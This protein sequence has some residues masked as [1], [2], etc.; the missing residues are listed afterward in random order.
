MADVSDRD[1]DILISHAD[2][3][4]CAEV[5]N[6]E[7]YAK[8]VR[9]LIPVATTLAGLILAG[10]LR[11]AAELSARVPW[12][13]LLNWLILL[14]TSAVLLLT[15]LWAVLFMRRRES[16]GTE[17]EDGTTADNQRPPEI[18]ASYSLQLNESDIETA[19]EALS[20]LSYQVFAHT[21]TAALNLRTR[22]VEERRRIRTSERFVAAG[23]LAAIVTLVAYGIMWMVFL[24]SEAE[25][26]GQDGA[27]TEI[28]GSNGLGEKPAEGLGEGPAGGEGPAEGPGEAPADG[29][30][31]G[32][33]ENREQGSGN[34]ND[35]RSDEAG[36]GGRLPRC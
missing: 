22:N 36:P 10:G 3:M 6:A 33:G 19:A 25:N 13:V 34:P 7:R 27:Q 15:G 21:L 29:L 26:N 8:R 35:P 14:V 30:G 2:R 18:T 12:W 17:G 9:I 24:E 32:S 11:A 20:A 23:I 5:E 4:W 28:I 1:T 31:A 16:A